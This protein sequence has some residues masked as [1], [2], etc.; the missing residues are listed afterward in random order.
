[1]ERMGGTD[2]KR[3]AELLKG[4]SPLKNAWMKNDLEKKTLENESG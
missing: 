3:T 2:H 4:K 1:M